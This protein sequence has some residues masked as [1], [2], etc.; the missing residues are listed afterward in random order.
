MIEQYMSEPM[1]TV[2]IED[3]LS[4]IRRLVSEDLRPTQRLV[5]AALQ[6][7][8]AKL[9][10]TPA[11]RIVPDVRDMQPERAKP[12]VNLQDSASAPD[13]IAVEEPE[14]TAEIVPVFGSVRTSEI[15]VSTMED[16]LNGTTDANFLASAMSRING[17]SAMDMV[18]GTDRQKG[19]L[20]ENIEAVVATVGAAVGPDE[21]EVDGGDPAPQD[22]AWNAEPWT[23]KI[24]EVATAK[25]HSVLV[26]GAADIVV[27]GDISS[28]T[29]MHDNQSDTFLE[30]ETGDLAAYHTGADSIVF[31][32]AMPKVPVVANPDTADGTEYIDEDA[33]RSLVQDMI[34]QELQGGLGE[35]I[36][37]NVRKLVRA[38]INRALAAHVYDDKARA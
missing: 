31:N 34:R 26:L 28:E 23:D 9:I 25:E 36:T 18:H 8:A 17:L 5:S 7:G 38:E 3:V 29:V 16:S 27:T 11:L 13:D 32:H 10:L 30:Q 37:S 22:N 14:F 19:Q 24:D 21:W 15:R 1:S 6:K 20:T 33:L 12:F 35:R 4:S 2:E